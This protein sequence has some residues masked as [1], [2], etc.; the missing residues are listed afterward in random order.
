MPKNLKF[1][2]KLMY[3]NTLYRNS[4]FLLWLALLVFPLSN[5]AQKTY[6]FEHIGKEKGLSQGTI[7]SIFQDSRGLMWFG[8]SDGLNS[9]DGVKMTVYRYRHDNPN[10]LQSNNILSLAEDTDGRIWVGTF[11]GNIQYFDPISLIFHTPSLENIDS[12]VFSGIRNAYSIA[13][14]SNGAIWVGTTDGL[15]RINPGHKSVEVI[16]PSSK[17]PDIE[18]GSIYALLIDNG[19][20]WIGMENGGLATLDLYTQDILVYKKMQIEREFIVETYRGTIMSIAKGPDGKLYAGTFGDYIYLI[21]E[22]SQALKQLNKELARNRDTGYGFIRSMI[23]ID[24]SNLW[25]GTNSGGIQILNV[26]TLE[27]DMIE[28]IPYKPFSLSYNNI[29]SIYK[30]KQGGI[31]IGTNGMGIDYHFPHTKNFGKM[32]AVSD[33]LYGLSFNSVR[34]IYRDPADGRLWVSGYNGLDVFD[35]DLKRQTIYFGN[36]GVYVIHPD[37]DDNNILWVGFEG[38]GLAKMDKRNGIVL[39]EFKDHWIGNQHIKGTVIHSLADGPGET[40]WVGTERALNLLDKKNNTVTIYMHKPEDEQS[41]P[42]FRIRALYNDSKGRLWVGTLGGGLAYLEAD[43]NTFRRF[44]TNSR[45]NGVMHSNTIFC[46]F[47]NSSGHIYI[48]TDLG[49]HIFDEQTETFQ[50]LTTVDGLPNDVIYGILEDESGHLWISTNEGISKYDPVNKHFTNYDTRDGLQA[51]EFN[52]GAFFRDHE[53]IMYFGGINGL[54]YFK[55]SE[56]KE[57]PIIPDIIFTSLSINNK[58]AELEKPIWK[59]KSLN[60]LYTENNFSLEFAALN[61]YKPTNNQ[62]AYKFGNQDDWIELG[63]NNRIDFINVKPGNYE[64]NI[65]ASNNDDKWNTEG[66]SMQIV[67]SPPFQETMWFYLLLGFIGFLLMLLYFYLRIGSIRKQK[68]KLEKEVELR[69]KE[70]QLEIAERE[71]IQQKLAESNSTKDKFFSIIAHDLRS[72]FN[73]LLG[74][75][76]LLTTDYES[77]TETEKKQAIKSMRNSTEKLYNLLE[78][79]LTWSRSQRG[80]IEMNQERFNLKEAVNE[81]LAILQETASRKSIKFDYATDADEVYVFADRNMLLTVVR[82]IVSNAIKYSK[83][84]DNITINIQDGERYAELEIRDNGIG[85][86]EQDKAKLFRIEEQFTRKGTANESGTGLG[87]IICKEFIEKNKGHIQVQSELGHGT[88]FLLKIPKQL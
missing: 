30:D 59:T 16:I 45:Q 71:K 5:H 37:P 79:L 51:N 88:S 87:L 67:I 83:P 81:T 18:A 31:W 86:G 1:T 52:S 80:I 82:N 50:V 64:L 43:K 54:N 28:P 70:L 58:H 6:S 24:D 48:G 27:N 4:C 3:N 78:N 57:N 60:L 12:T 76:E 53:G 47:E 2:H 9:Y 33:V 10:G 55:P 72:P 62:Y 7:N 68:N 20:L 63:N 61:Y 19:K 11:G 73:A 35:K 77:F 17:H 23:A 32:T 49:L 13:P 21:D 22:Q 38:S 84:N 74:F 56:I 29:K 85:I 8:T 26:Y 41:L 69:T 66:I 14:Q 25:A 42:D 15:F 39:R 46:I 40:L 75:M 34:S 36:Y 44:Y 65:I